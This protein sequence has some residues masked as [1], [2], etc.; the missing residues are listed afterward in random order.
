MGKVNQQI[1]FARHQLQLQAQSS[2]S[3]P[4]KANQRMRNQGMLYAGIWHLRLA[5]RYYLSEVG[6]NYKLTKPEQAADAVHLSAA[7]EAINKHPAEAQELQRLESS[8][9]VGDILDV[10]KMIEQIEA[11]LIPAAPSEVALAD[12]LLPMKDITAEKDWSELT[13]DNLEDWIKRFKELVDRH[14]EH[15]IEY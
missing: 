2:D 12:N 6:A 14:R 9:F 11:G 7:L 5:Y 8:G 15:M 3:E 10:L 13:V 1:I 4:L